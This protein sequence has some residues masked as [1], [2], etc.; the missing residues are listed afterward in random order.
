M[1]GCKKAYKEQKSKADTLEKYCNGLIKE[2]I[3]ANKIIELLNKKIY[4]L[5]HEKR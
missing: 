4:D 1:I 3:E 5:K 2:L